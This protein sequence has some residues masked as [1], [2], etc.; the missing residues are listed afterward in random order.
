MIENASYEGEQIQKIREEH[1]TSRAILERTASLGTP[2]QD[3]L[4]SGQPEGG[5][6]GTADRERDSGREADV[7]GL[8]GNEQPAKR[9]YSRKGRADTKVDK[10]DGGSNGHSNSINGTLQRNAT[11]GLDEQEKPSGL[12]IKPNNKEKR[13]RQEKEQAAREAASGGKPDKK[14]IFGWLRPDDKSKSEKDTRS[15]PLSEKEAQD[16][17]EPLKAASA[18]Y[19]VYADEL[20]YATHKAHKQVNIWSSIDDEELDILVDVWIARAKK[21]VKSANHVAGIINRH[22]ELKIGLILAPRFYQT[23]RVYVDGGGMG[24][25]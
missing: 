21:S 22:N 4:R 1:G 19:F 10:G 20:I 23:F 3:E 9:R 13:A 24:V 8:T 7:G 5:Q 6:S 16:I 15:K 11:G 2:I 17:R 18:D 25:K 12:G 14:D